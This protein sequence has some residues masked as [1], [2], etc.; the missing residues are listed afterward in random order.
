M[1]LKHLKRV[2]DKEIPPY[3]NEE[4]KDLPE[5]GDF[6]LSP[7]Y[8]ENSEVTIAVPREEGDLGED[9]GTFAAGGGGGGLPSDEE[10]AQLGMPQ[11]VW[12]KLEAMFNEKYHQEALESKGSD[13]DDEGY[14]ED[15]EDDED[16]DFGYSETDLDDAVGCVAICESPDIDVD[17]IASMAY[18]SVEPLAFEKNGQTY[19]AYAWV[20]GV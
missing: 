14:G 1:N 7:N 18:W 15:D 17:S 4:G 12:K 9:N 3:Y 5:Y 2:Q 11:R 10:V 8:H 16:A 6:E 19:W 20:A 13:E